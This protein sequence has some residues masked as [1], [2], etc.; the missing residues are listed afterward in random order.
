MR[1]PWHFF[2]AGPIEFGPKYKWADGYARVTE[3]GTVEFPWLRFREAQSQ[4]KKYGGKA[5]FHETKEDAIS[6]MAA[7]EKKS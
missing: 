7:E 5:I 4:A 1:E 2:R 6:A 3:D